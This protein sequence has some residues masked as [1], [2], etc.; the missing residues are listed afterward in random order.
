[1]RMGR[2]IGTQ[3]LGS[4]ENTAVAGFSSDGGVSD[5]STLPAEH[6]AVYFYM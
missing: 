2:K 6:R 5:S 3:Q 1:M 4:P